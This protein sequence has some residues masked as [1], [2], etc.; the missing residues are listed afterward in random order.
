MAATARHPRT[1]TPHHHTG[2]AS[3]PIT[4]VTERNMIRQPIARGDDLE[5][6]L[7]DRSMRLAEYVL[8][9]V[10]IVAAGILAF[11]R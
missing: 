8:A 6:D 10:A 5:L 4:N 1:P 2:A 7:D 11:V 3:R 9:I